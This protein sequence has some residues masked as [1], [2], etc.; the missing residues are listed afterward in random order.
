MNIVTRVPFHQNTAPYCLHRDSAVRENL[1]RVWGRQG[2]EGSKQVV[3]SPG[4]TSRDSPAFRPHDTPHF[5]FGLKSEEKTWGEFFV[6]FCFGDVGG[7]ALTRS[8]G[9]RFGEN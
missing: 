1:V 8:L 6:L 5:A 7:L 3:P 9:L 4:K 2:I